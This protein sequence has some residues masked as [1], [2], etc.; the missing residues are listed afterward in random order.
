[1]AAT[2]VIDD[3]L[4]LP[5]GSVAVHGGNGY[6]CCAQRGDL[7][8]LVN[9]SEATNLPLEGFEIDHKSKKWADDDCDCNG[10][11]P[12]PFTASVPVLGLLP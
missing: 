4:P 7:V 5:C 1:M 12:Q 2:K 8:V 11:Q 9:V 3:S 6:V 10:S